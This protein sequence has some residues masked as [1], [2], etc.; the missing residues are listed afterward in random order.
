MEWCPQDL[1]RNNFEVDL[2][3]RKERCVDTILF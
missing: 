1:V 2:V 3:R